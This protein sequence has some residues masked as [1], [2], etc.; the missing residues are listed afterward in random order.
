MIAITAR[1]NRNGR[2]LTTPFWERKSPSSRSWI[3]FPIFFRLFTGWTSS[4]VALISSSAISDLFRY[5]EFCTSCPAVVLRLRFTRNDSPSGDG[6]QWG[7]YVPVEIFGLDPF[8]IPGF[9][10]VL[11]QFVF[12][13]VVGDD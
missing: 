1:K 8:E 3:G 10:I 2:L 6:F 12:Q 9:D 4:G 13:R 5:S 7:L 11:D